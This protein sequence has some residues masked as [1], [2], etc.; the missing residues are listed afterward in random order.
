[1]LWAPWDRGEGLP[2]LPGFFPGEA[3]PPFLG[4]GERLPPLPSWAWI[5][6]M[7]MPTV[8][9]CS[10]LEGG[11]ILFSPLPPAP[12]NQNSQGSWCYRAFGVATLADFKP[13]VASGRFG[14]L[15]ACIPRPPGIYHS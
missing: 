9:F 14:G 13:G 2:S 11:E 6:S 7:R 1:M 15:V 8:T 10:H 12:A 3:S 4:L 5:A